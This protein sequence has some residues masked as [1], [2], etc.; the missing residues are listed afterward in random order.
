[1]LLIAI[2]NTIAECPRTDCNVLG[3][4]ELGVCELQERT[5]LVGWQHCHKEFPPGSP[6]WC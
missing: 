6:P 4:E 3:G 1:M 5:P 2:S